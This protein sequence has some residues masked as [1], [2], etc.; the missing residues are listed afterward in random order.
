MLAEE[1]LGM[2]LRNTLARRMLEMYGYGIRMAKRGYVNLE[3]LKTVSEGFG[4][5]IK[6]TRYLRSEFMKGFRDGSS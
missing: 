6:E 1:I 2:D 4:Y 3:M 5:D